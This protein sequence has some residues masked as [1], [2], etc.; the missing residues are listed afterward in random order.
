MRKIRS[1]T[2]EKSVRLRILFFFDPFDNFYGS[3]AR[4]QH[5]SEIKQKM[6][7]LIV[8]DNASMRKLIRSI[9]SDLAAEIEEC[10]DGADVLDA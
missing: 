7:L 6:K 1:L 8:E 2:D 4:I 10:G 9:V 5:L 3:K